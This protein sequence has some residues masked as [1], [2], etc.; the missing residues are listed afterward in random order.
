MFIMDTEDGTISAWNGGTTTTLVVD[1]SANS[2]DGDPNVQPG[3]GVGAVYKGLAIGTLK[4][5]TTLLYATNFRHGT[6]DVFNSQWQQ[7]NSLTDGDLPAGYAPFNV[8]ALKGDLFVS[9]AQQ[10]AFKHGDVAGQ[11]HGYIDE[12]SLSGKLVARVASN[13]P[14]T[15]LGEWPSRQKILASLPVTSLS[16]ISATAQS[17]HTI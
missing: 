6:V 8:Q 1:N 9:Y 16:A 15:R 7:V 14:L 12:F 3:E 10:D 4:N 5:G 11:G 13:G 2:A 17:T